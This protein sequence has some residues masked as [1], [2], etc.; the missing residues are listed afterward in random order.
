MPEFRESLSQ[1]VFVED[2]FQLVFQDQT[3]AVFSG[4]VLGKAG[5]QFRMGEPGF[6]D[7]LVQLIGQQA[8]AI[9]A[10]APFLLAIKFQRG[11]TL[12]IPQD[13]T[14][15]EAYSLHDGTRIVVGRDA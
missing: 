3:L 14:G 15:P 9:P 13:G 10:C 6:C 12:Q 11:A 4:A 2:Y 5:V 8:K 1:V 7:A